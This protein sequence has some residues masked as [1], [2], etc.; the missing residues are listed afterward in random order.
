[1]RKYIGEGAFVKLSFRLFLFIFHKYSLGLL[2][3]FTITLNNCLN[4]SN[5]T[6]FAFFEIVE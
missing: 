2:H 6:S 4:N 1:M 5:G 3:L